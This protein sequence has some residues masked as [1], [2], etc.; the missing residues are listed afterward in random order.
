MSKIYSIEEEYMFFKKKQDNEVVSKISIN[1]KL[2]LIENSKEIYKVAIEHKKASGDFKNEKLLNENYLKESCRI[3]SSIIFYSAKIVYGVE[4]RNNKVLH[5]EVRYGI[6]GFK[7]SHYLNYINGEYIDA[8]IEQFNYNSEGL[9]FSADADN[10]KYYHDIEEV[11]PLEE[12]AL[13]QELDILYIFDPFKI[14]SI[15]SR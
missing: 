2:E 13:K 14:F 9:L 6:N 1:Q 3:V 10:S 12:C 5:C 4:D 11:E 8:S 15:K 7:A